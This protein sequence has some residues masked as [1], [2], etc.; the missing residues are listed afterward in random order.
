[1]GVFASLL[2]F[3]SP[4]R[5]AAADA[6]N[7]VV[8][9]RLLLAVFDLARPDLGSPHAARPRESAG[10]HLP[11]GVHDG[12][13]GARAVALAPFAHP[14][15]FCSAHLRADAFDAADTRRRHPQLL[16]R[17]RPADAVLSGLWGQVQP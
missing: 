14:L 17:H 9:H 10:S 2:E 7:L 3:A 13:S 1:M 4:Q 12:D 5:L 16:V 8:L 11:S 6:R 15:A